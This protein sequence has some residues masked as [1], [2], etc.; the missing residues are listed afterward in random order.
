MAR[1]LKKR[2]AR[3]QAEEAG[4]KQSIQDLKLKNQAKREA[5]KADMA[6]L[7]EA[8]KSKSPGSAPTAPSRVTVDGKTYTSQ[9][10]ADMAM[11][12]KKLKAESETTKR[13]LSNQKARREAGV[14]EAYQRTEAS[15]EV[16]KMRK[17]D[18]SKRNQP[19]PTTQTSSSNNSEFSKT[20]SEE[21]KKQ[22]AG[23]NFA[24]KGKSYTTNLKE[25]ES[26]M[27]KHGGALAI[28]IA[29]VKTKNKKTVKA[30]KKGAKAQNGGVV[31]D[32]LK[33]K[34]KK[35]EEARRTRIL[36]DKKDKGRLSR[37]KAEESRSGGTSG[38]VKKMKNGG[39]VKKGIINHKQGY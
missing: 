1:L 18:P 35:R 20:F 28:M 11:E 13:G 19:K 23:G 22:G 6:A 33:S 21:R 14:G 36:I 27:A 17:S 39:K 16:R 29:P 9:K 31:K 24:F 8:K 34:S 7:A 37:L 5:K 15:G 3:K 25:E 30:I 26:N 2:R 4:R 12:R 38:K 10:A 32:L